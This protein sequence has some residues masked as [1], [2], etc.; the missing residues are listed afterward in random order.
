WLRKLPLYRSR[1]RQGCLPCI[2]PI[3]S[4]GCAELYKSSLNGNMKQ[5]YK[6][7]SIRHHFVQA[8]YNGKALTAY[9]NL[10][11][12]YYH[13]ADRGKEYLFAWRQPAASKIS[14]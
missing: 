14:Y 5:A 8:T 7:F 12:P 9:M 10:P 4:A 3:R 1:S 2:F 6:D 11:V 13:S